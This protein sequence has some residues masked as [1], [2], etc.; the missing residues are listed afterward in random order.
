MDWVQLD[1]F[2]RSSGTVKD[3]WRMGGDS[4]EIVV[5]LADGTYERADSYTVLKLHPDK[6]KHTRNNA[7][8]YQGGEWFTVGHGMDMG[9]TWYCSETITGKKT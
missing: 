6:T 3:I 5:G 4:W 7:I 9:H 1:D 8:T 2:D